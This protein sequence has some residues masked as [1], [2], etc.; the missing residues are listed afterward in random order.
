M[1]ESISATSI[2]C[3]K[4]KL[5]SIQ[6]ILRYGLVGILINALGYFVYLIITYNGADPKCTMTALYSFGVIISFFANRRFTFQHNGHMGASGVGYLLVQVLG[7]L[8]NLCLL[9]LFVDWLGFSHQIV[10]AIAIVIVA[11]FLFVMLR[12]FVFVPCLVKK[13]EMG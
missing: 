11:V 1:A 12:V 9:L 5:N 6:Q 8:L 4:L 7:Y 13:K 3:N 2:L 10:Q